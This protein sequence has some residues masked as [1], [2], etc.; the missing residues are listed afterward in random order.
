MSSLTLAVD[1]SLRWLSLGL[2]DASELYGEESLNAGRSQAEILPEAVE[3]F[4]PRFG[5][6]LS[7]VAR[8][9][10]TAG[11]GYYT[12][13]R[14]G[15]SYAAALAEG[16]GVQVAPVCSLRAI[17]YNFTESGINAAPFVRARR[18][19]VY[20][21]LFAG[22]GVSRIKDIPPALYG[23]AEFIGTIKD[24]GLSRGDVL[25]VGV[26][27]GEFAGIEN[28][29]YIVVTAPP[30]TGL[31]AARAGLA[32]PAMDPASVRAEYIREPA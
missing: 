7:D 26:D 22:R 3:N 32:G 19:E 14:V 11:P 6:A 2:A 20:G 1:C 24:C 18:G 13:I 29:G 4:L 21:A 17:A 10:V 8:M 16:L 5:F 9:A 28:S 25:L 30:C 15:L 23:E 12:G 31:S 27:R